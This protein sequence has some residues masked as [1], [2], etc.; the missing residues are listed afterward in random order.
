MTSTTGIVVGMHITGT[1][2]PAGRTIASI[3]SSSSVTLNSGTSVT[4][5]T[6]ADLKIG[7]YPSELPAYRWSDLKVLDNF[8]RFALGSS[9]GYVY[10]LSEQYHQ[11]NTADIE[12]YITTKDYELNKGLTFLLLE[13]IVRISLRETSIGFLTGSEIDVRASVDYGRTWSSWVTLAI[14][15]ATDPEN[16]FMEKKAGFHMRGK[17]VR[18]QFRSYN[19]FK[20]ESCFIKWNPTGKEFKY[21]R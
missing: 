9:T 16:Y 21:N 10:E 15:P 14:D 17:A 13:L 3:V 1:G 4:A 19:P 5:S 20:L 6:V 18:F 8:T 2:I 12:S 11:D 7:W